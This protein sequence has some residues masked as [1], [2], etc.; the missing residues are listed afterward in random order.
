[1]EN[2]SFTRGK[3]RRS[4][5]SGDSVI[6]DKFKR[7]LERLRVIS[8]LF[9]SQSKFS[10]HSVIFYEFPITRLYRDLRSS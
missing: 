6:L 4:V 7:R 1:M 10:R 2:P 5:K 9:L 3:K 8:N